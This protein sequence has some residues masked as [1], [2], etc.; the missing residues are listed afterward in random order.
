[1]VREYE[2]ET[3]QARINSFLLLE[4]N[5]KCRGTKQKPPS[6]TKTPWTKAPLGQKP[7]NNEIII[8]SYYICFIFLLILKES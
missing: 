4:N 2:D 6:Q 3:N 5:K 7:P 1:L 8:Q